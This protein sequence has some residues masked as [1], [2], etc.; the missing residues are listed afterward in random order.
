MRSTFLKSTALGAL[1]AIAMGGAPA[2]AQTSGDQVPEQESASQSGQVSPD[3]VVAT[4]DDTEIVNADVTEFI[5]T[6]PPRMREQP[7]QMLL[8]MA[9]EQVILRELLLREAQSLD[10]SSDRRVQEIAQADAQLAE[11]D[12]MVAIY[13][14]D[15]LSSRVSD[16]EIEQ[17][18]RQLHEQVSDDQSLPPLDALRP[19]IAQQ[20]QGQALETLRAELVESAEIV[21]YGADGAQSGDGSRGDGGSESGAASSDSQ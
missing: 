3:T 2:L 16:E 15:E 19:Q 12:A 10:L 8:S 11:E 20:L 4:V 17:A 9:L 6:L 1:A 14:Q 18:Y 21:V 7:R 5:S 13:L